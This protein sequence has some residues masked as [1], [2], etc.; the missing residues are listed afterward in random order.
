M[1]LIQRK[2]QQ[3]SPL[4]LKPHWNILLFAFVAFIFYC[5]GYERGNKFNRE[6]SKTTKI[7]KPPPVKDLSTKPL[8]RI[9]LPKQT[10]E[11]YL[12]EEEDKKLAEEAKRNETAL[13]SPVVF[14][15]PWLHSADVAWCDDSCPFSNNGNC[16][17]GRSVPGKDKVENILCDLGTDCSDCGEWRL[18][19]PISWKVEH[20]IEMLRQKNVSVH[21]AELKFPIP[22]SVA[23]TNP[24]NDVDF[25]M[26]ILTDQ[27]VDPHLTKIWYHILRS[28]C[29]G[30]DGNMVVDV[31]AHFGYYSLMS[32]AMGC[33][34]I[35]YEP[36]PVFNAFL[37]YSLIRNKLVHRV[38]V[39]ETVVGEN[40]GEVFTLVIPPQGLWS[41]NTVSEK[42]HRSRGSTNENDDG[43]LHYE[44]IS[45]TI[46][47]L[48]SVLTEAHDS[49]LLLKVDAEGFEPSVMRSAQRLFQNQNNSIENIL[50]NYSPVVAERKMDWGWY[51]NFPLML[52]NLLQQHGYAA[53]HAERL[54]RHDVDFDFSVLPEFKRISSRVLDYDLADAHLL[55]RGRLGCPL[56]REVEFVSEQ[57]SQPKMFRC[58]SIPEGIDPRSFRSTFRTSTDVWLVRNDSN[59]LPHFNGMA[60]LF[61]AD[62]DVDKYFSPHEWGVGGEMCA[63]V[64]P[65]EQISKRCHCTD[66][67]I[68]GA[69]EKAVL[70]AAAERQ[71]PPNGALKLFAEDLQDVEKI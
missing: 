56:P 53:A 15:P 43:L 42:G 66:D 37:K 27:V 16:D 4:V 44:K 9:P 13:A 5:I 62:Y 68:C 51:G 6:I 32:A 11:D 21:V 63:K 64:S 57:G 20:P 55:Q 30:G 19:A 40:Q 26:Q 58:N 3:P 39:R 52:K 46:E 31:G 38:D 45:R 1:V 65:L 47:R 50:L 29:R 14:Q 24:K 23:Y 12:K 22:F 69:L 8:K 25:S 10:I 35:A 17:D 54:H 70:Q 34:V 33:R 41:S 49:Y 61:P 67:E 36:V 71:M 2:R 48:D 28:G 59:S 18:T 60:Q 7:E